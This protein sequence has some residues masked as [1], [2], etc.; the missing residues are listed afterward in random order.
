MSSILG[1]R[2]SSTG[3]EDYI[4]DLTVTGTLDIAGG[5]L[6][7]ST[8]TVIMGPTSF[9][10]GTQT[11][12]GIKFTSDSDTGLFRE[13]ANKI[14]IT[15]G[16]TKR[17]SLDT[18]VIT[19]TLPIRGANGSVS[20]PQYSFSASGSSDTGMYC[21]QS[22]GDLL[23]F[24]VGGVRFLVMDEKTGSTTLETGHLYTQDGTDA[25]PGFSFK[26]ETGMGIDRKSAGNMGFS[27][28]GSNRAVIN[29]TGLSI[30]SGGALTV[31]M[32]TLASQPI[33]FSGDSGSG[34][35]SSNNDAVPAQGVS[36]DA[37]GNQIATFIH[38]GLHLKKGS[39]FIY[40]D[41]STTTPAISFVNALD[42]GMHLYEGVWASGALCANNT[43]IF[44]W[45]QYGTYF[46]IAQYCLT[47][48]TAS[49][50]AYSFD[51]NHATGIF[52]QDPADNL[53]I[54]T[55]GTSRFK[56]SESLG[57]INGLQAEFQN[58]VILSP[59]IDSTATTITN[60]D[61]STSFVVLGNNLAITLHGIT[62]ASNGALLFLT[63]ASTFALTIKH[64]SGSAVGAKIFT[65]TSTDLVI[66][67]NAGVI[68]GYYDGIWNVIATN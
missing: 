42:I 46:D 27:T 63:R 54:S 11:V 34:I 28:A 18:S 24:A 53:C 22:S 50:P 32:G 36:L 58:R 64:N 25:L 59:T 16:G 21:G 30:S 47:R 33:Q 2:K 5:T 68:F 14:A 26:N 40:E 35:H 1:K 55:N 66:T 44:Y 49:V 10:D 9:P 17:L 65:R 38:N 15:T 12:P 67:G 23:Q 19:S 60:L 39:M 37:N 31:P 43:D 29:S 52:T 20:A 13:S 7:A 6:D 45:D 4:D 51:E 57:I 41:G 8:A 56:V 3:E 48:G 62:A 61:S